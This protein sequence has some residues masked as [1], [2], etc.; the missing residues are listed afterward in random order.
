MILTLAVIPTVLIIR[1]CQHREP[2]S[3][4]PLRTLP[5]CKNS[6]LISSVCS[7]RAGIGP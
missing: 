7:P 4:S 3:K 6:F 1:A 5:Y 2:E